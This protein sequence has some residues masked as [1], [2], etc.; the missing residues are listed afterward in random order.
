MSKGLSCLVSPRSTLA[1]ERIVLFIHDTIRMVWK[2]TERRW[3]NVCKVMTFSFAR[4][5]QYIEGQENRCGEV[6]NGGDR[7]SFAVIQRLCNARCSLPGRIEYYPAYIHVHIT[8][9]HVSLWL[10]FLSSYPACDWH[11]RAPRKNVDNANMELEMDSLVLA[12]SCT[13]LI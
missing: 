5:I 6:V 1:N 4:S 10:M 13:D 2:W 8:A 12:V 11:F 9:T 7:S 3:L